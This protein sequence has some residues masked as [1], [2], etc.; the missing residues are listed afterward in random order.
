MIELENHSPFPAMVY[1]KAS[2]KNRFF[3]VLAIKG[4]FR[5]KTDG[6]RADLAD[7]Q[8]P[9]VMADTYQTD[10]P[11]TSSLRHETDLILGKLRTDVHVIGHAYSPHGKPLRTWDTSIRLG[12][13]KKSLR[14]YGPRE[15]YYA[16]MGWN[17]DEAE[18]VSKVPLRYELAYGGTYLPR[19]GKVVESFDT[20]PVGVG[21]RD[22]LWLDSAK[23]YPAPQN[24]AIKIQ[25]L[26]TISARHTPDGYGPLSRWWPQRAQYAGTY[27]DVWMAETWPFLPEDFNPAFYNSAPA[28]LQAD[29]FL[30][31]NE[32]L[33]LSGLLPDAWEVQT[34]LGAYIPACVVEDDSNTLHQFRP[35]L[36]TV[37]IDTDAREIHQTWRLSLP[38]EFGL[39]HIVLGSMAPVPER[40]GELQLLHFVKKP[41]TAVSLNPEK[42]K[43]D[44]LRWLVGPD[45]P[46]E[47]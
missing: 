35:R 16:R 21:F 1:E 5:L 12:A 38:R 25:L 17:L 4:S 10:D 42:D 33:V 28:G 32:P 3:D 39:R 29:G 44:R 30:S 46:Q 40:Q 34:A 15:W 11:L 36:E 37:T 14:V 45:G 41:G 20:N 26:N 8:K 24:V 22:T 23:R 31:G 6:T 27:D 9:L 18:A 47:R 19:K 7:K 13:L 2:Y 43:V